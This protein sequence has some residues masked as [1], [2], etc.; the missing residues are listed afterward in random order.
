M[1]SLQDAIALQPLQKYIN[2]PTVMDAQGNYTLIKNPDTGQWEVAYGGFGTNNTFA[3]TGGGDQPYTDPATGRQVAWSG[4]DAGNGQWK[5]VTGSDPENGYTLGD[6][7]SGSAQSLMLP[8]S[9]AEKLQADPNFMPQ[10]KRSGVGPVQQSRGSDW[11]ADYGFLVPGG[12]AAGAAALA[13]AAGGAG[14]TSLA[15]TP[16]SGAGSALDLATPL[17]QSLGGNFAAGAGSA[18]DLSVPLGSQVGAGV[19]GAAAPAAINANSLASNFGTTDSPI[20]WDAPTSTMSSGTPTTGSPFG[21]A[22]PGSALDIN[23]PL[24]SSLGNTTMTA[25]GGSPLDIYAP[26]GGAATGAGALTLSQL[27]QGSSV[28]TGAMTL[29]KML[30]LTGDGATAV[31]ALGKAV[32][33]LIGAYAANQQGSAL[34]DL[35]TKYS[36]YGAPSRARY[37]ASMAPGFDPNSIPGYSAAVDNSLDALL[38]RLSTQGNPFGNPGGLVEA[39]KAVV[40]GTAM[41]A[42]QEYQRA[43][44]AGGGLANMNAAVPG[45]DS[46]AIGANSNVYGALGDSAASI[47]TPKTQPTSLSELLRQLK[48]SGLALA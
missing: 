39:R 20:Q 27:A 29:S 12:L 4:D 5:Y 22:T 21:S 14:A 44:L 35:A 46:G 28:A 17:S 40:S 3:P 19:A 18:L 45:L 15:A 48:M 41:P 1:P 32:P 33:G 30:G 23:T 36:E 26:L 42:I 10:V 43:N 2:A 34:S 47:F 38:R 7:V 31:D 8:R 11:G 6:A 13:G 16:F 24:S 37:E 25:A 9:V